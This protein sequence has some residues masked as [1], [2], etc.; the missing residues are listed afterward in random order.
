MVAIMDRPGTRV[1]I[2]TLGRKAAAYLVGYLAS[3]LI[4]S[5][6]TISTVCLYLHGAKR[7]RNLLQYLM[8]SR[9]THLGL[10]RF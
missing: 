9:Y 8:S 2:G 7:G 5:D 6:L 3:S 4:S 1:L 10:D